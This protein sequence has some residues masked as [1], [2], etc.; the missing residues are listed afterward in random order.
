M[1]GLGWVLIV[2][3]APL[4]LGYLIGEKK[5]AMWLRL[6]LV[7]AGVGLLIVVIGAATS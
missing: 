6:G 3:A 7:M 5:N 4:L 1:A 2:L